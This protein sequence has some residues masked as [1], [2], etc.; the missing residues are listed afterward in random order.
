MTVN[1]LRFE[2]TRMFFVVF[3]SLIIIIVA[4]I[5]AEMANW[6]LIMESDTGRV[7]IDTSSIIDGPDSSKE[8]W[9]KTMYSMPYCSQN[10]C[11]THFIMY[12]RYFKNRTWNVLEI[13]SY[14]TDGTAKKVFIPKRDPIRIPPE[15]YGEKVWKFLYE[16]QSAQD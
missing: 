6:S 2:M 15:T 4:P 16:T 9:S 5:T 14:Y 8:L 7:Q 10:K 12:E 13:T 1:Q 3:V 11:T